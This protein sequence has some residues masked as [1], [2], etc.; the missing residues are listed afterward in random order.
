MPTGSDDYAYDDNDSRT[1]VSEANGAGSLDR[2]Y[3]YD[4]LDRLTSTRSAV[5]CS[6]GL[7]EAYEYD[8]AGNRRKV[9]VAVP[10]STTWYRYSGAGQLCEA[11]ATDGA[12]PADP[13]TWEIRYDATG[14]TSVWNGWTLTYDG[15][16]RL[17]SAC[18]VAGCATGDMVT[19]RYDGEGRRVELVTRPNGG[20]AT[21]TTFR[22]QGSAIAQELTGTG[23]LTLVRTYLTDEAGTIVKVCDPDCTQPNNPQYLVTY[24]G[25]GDALAL[26]RIETDG[27]LALANSYTYDTWGAPTVRDAAGNVL[28]WDAAANRR[29]RY[30]YVGAQGVAW[31]NALGLGLLHMGARH[32]SPAL[33]RFLQPDPSALE[34]NLYGYGANS[35]VSRVDPSGLWCQ[36][37]T[38]ALGPGGAAITFVGCAIDGAAIAWT[39]VGFLF[40]G[41]IA[42]GIQGD[43][44]RPRYVPPRI[45]QT[46]LL[47]ARVN[48]A[49][50]EIQR[51][52]APPGIRRADQGHVP[53]RGP[54]VHVNGGAIDWR[55][56]VAQPGHPLLEPL[57]NKQKAWLRKWG[58]PVR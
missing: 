8:D 35:P 1:R 47:L 14:R 45:I 19:M 6:S 10:S 49:D 2:H 38:L 4:A 31:D 43:T 11:G 44:P 13:A 12:C 40:A 51:G 7:L 26:W 21:T 20:A 18:R 34:T 37:F 41:F 53:G 52:R 58:I 54:H 22:Y 17:S 36:P 5:G 9:V 48:Q 3:C 24:N 25:H 55:T 32:Y 28:A 42:W 46:L 23:T 16:G 57:N 39:A 50:R 29:F 27:S 15:E 56:G 33:G 30:L